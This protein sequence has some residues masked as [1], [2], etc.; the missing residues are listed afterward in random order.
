MDVYI[1]Q[2]DMIK[3]RDEKIE[4][5]QKTLNEQAINNNLLQDENR[6]LKTKILPSEGP[7]VWVGNII[8]SLH[9][10][11]IRSANTGIYI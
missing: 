1:F 11:Q 5:L 9:K 4:G 8:T 10:E 6:K 3:A 7:K 2:D